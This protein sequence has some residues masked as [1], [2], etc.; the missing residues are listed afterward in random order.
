MR[1]TILICLLLVA[2]CGRGD[3]EEYRVYTE[4]PRLIL[5][6]Q[7]LRLLKR[8]RERDSRRWRQLDLLL[9]GSVRMPEP[10]FALAL[11]YAVTDDSAAGKRAVDWALG[12]VD[13]LLRRHEPQC[14]LDMTVSG[15]LTRPMLDGGR[16]SR[17][18]EL[19]TIDRMAASTEGPFAVRSNAR[20]AA[21]AR[22]FRIKKGSSA[23]AS[24]LP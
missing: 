10:G 18:D 21:T 15:L 12:G 24:S 16:L 2:F 14:N 6:A 4:H 5:T 17:P 8:E 9:K 11:Y 20:R 1:F 23:C 22:D 19:S 3:E 13:D 7:R